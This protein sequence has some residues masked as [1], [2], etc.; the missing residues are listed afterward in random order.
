MAYVFYD[1]ETT[2]TNTSFDQILEFAA[3][4]TDSELRELDRFTIRCRLL[5]HV[6]PSPR[7][8]R[9]TQVTPARLHDSRLPSHYE[10]MTAIHE[11]LTSWSPANFVGFNSIAFDEVLMRQAFFQSLY[12]PYLTNTLGNVRSDVLRLAHSTSIYAPSVLTVPR[13]EADRPVFK[14]DRLAVENGYREHTAHQA[15]GD[16]LA[17]LFLARLIRNQA[18]DVWQLMTRTTTRKTVADYVRRESSFT[19]SETYYNRHYSWLVTLCG[20]NPDRPSQLAVFD[21]FFDPQDYLSCSVDELVRILNGKNNPIRTLAAN[22]QPVLMPADAAPPDTRALEIDPVERRRRTELIQTDPA[23]RRRVGEALASRFETD[24]QSPYVEQQIYERFLTR[25]DGELM[26]KF[27]R[28][29]WSERVAIASQFKD[30]RLFEFA[31]RAIFFEHPEV[32]PSTVRADWKAWLSDRV[33]VEGNNVPWTTV[34][35]A[36]RDTEALLYDARGGDAQFLQEIKSFLED[37][38]ERSALP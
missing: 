26:A 4:R 35:T 28:V 29:P 9:V 38:S 34:N 12:P 6:I 7:A 15:L 19:V 11:K 25:E 18:P 8:L 17:T 22:K 16:V 3:V 37:V 23:F 13:T 10:M 36:L 21:L 33:C 14:L 30:R 5:P 32:L 20:E 2:G 31:H 27:H 1:T 24:T